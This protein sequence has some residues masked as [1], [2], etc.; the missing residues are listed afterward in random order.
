M[1][2]SI[3]PCIFHMKRYH[4]RGYRITLGVFESCV[5]LAQNPHKDFLHE[6]Q[7]ATTV[8]LKLLYSSM[9]SSIFRYGSWYYYVIAK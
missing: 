7:G 9:F 4:F 1:A 8:H 2:R 6:Y 5:D 3:F